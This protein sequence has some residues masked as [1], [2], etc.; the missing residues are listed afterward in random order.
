MKRF[1]RKKLR[2]WLG[3]TKLFNKINTLNDLI[4]ALDVALEHHTVRI[5]EIERT[6]QAYHESIDESISAEVQALKTDDKKWTREDI[7]YW[8][9]MAS[10]K[11]DSNDK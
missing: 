2:R 1:I 11:E 10:Y 4:N 7:A 6:E 3:I 8:E 9:Y 5:R